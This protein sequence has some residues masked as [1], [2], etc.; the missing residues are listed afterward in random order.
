MPLISIIQDKQLSLT[1]FF[2]LATLGTTG[3]CAFDNLRSICEI[4]KQHHCYVHVDGAYAGNAF[5]CEE[6]RYLM[7][8]IE[9][10]D[11]FAFNPSKWM[12]VHFDCTAMW[13]QSVVSLHRTFNVNPLYLKHENTGLAIDYM[14]W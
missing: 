12:N 5:I 11:S 3:C 10:V 6:F 2:I 9:L 14:H 13:L 7:D 4:A 1:P 8:G